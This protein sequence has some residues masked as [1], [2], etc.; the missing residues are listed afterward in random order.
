[1][2]YVSYFKIIINKEEKKNNVKKYFIDKIFNNDRYSG[3][4][5][6]ELFDD[7]YYL[8]WYTFEDDTLKVS[9][10]FPD[11][12]I[13]INVEG[14]EIDD[15]F[16]YEF[17]NGKYIKY[18]PNDWLRYIEDNIDSSQYNDLKQSFLDNNVRYRSDPIPIAS[19]T[20]NCDLI[21]SFMQMHNNMV[22]SEQTIFN[23]SLSNITN[24][25]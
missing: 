10:L 17:E 16:I 2:S 24:M 22:K 8:K 18:N 6:N 7:G 13:T 1:M 4:Y 9:S 23:L 25:F 14:E 3:E 11:I 12:K 19:E 21:D 20:R 15:K 5:I